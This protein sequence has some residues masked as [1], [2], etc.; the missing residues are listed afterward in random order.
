MHIYKTRKNWSKKP[1]SNKSKK[2]KTKTNGLEIFNVKTI[3]IQ[4]R[5]NRLL[6][7]RLAHFE[8]EIT[9][10][11]TGSRHFF[12]AGPR[13]QFFSRFPLIFSMLISSNL[14]ISSNKVIFQLYFEHAIYRVISQVSKWWRKNF[15]YPNQI[16]IFDGWLWTNSKTFS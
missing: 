7:Y 15:R 1:H 5:E 11:K 6:E 13:M 8:K 10:P 12:E 3:T 16:C 2:N 14:L 9:R 4:T